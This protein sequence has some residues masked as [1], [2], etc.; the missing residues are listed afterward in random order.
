VCVVDAEEMEYPRS[1]GGGGRQEQQQEAHERAAI[2]KKIELHRKVFPNHAVV[3]WYR[4]VR[5]GGGRGA[6]AGSGDGDG[7][8]DRDDREDDDDDDD[9]P[10]MPTEEDLRVTRTEIGGHY[11]RRPGGGGAGEDA[12][13]GGGGPPLFLLMDASS[14]AANDGKKPASSSSSSSGD[15]EMDEELPLTVYE[16]ISSSSSPSPG[17]GGVAFVNADFELETYEPERIAVERVFR[18][19]P[20]KATS[21]SA[22]GGRGAASTG[23]GGDGAAA[24]AAGG[25]RKAG[26][27]SKKDAEERGR[28]GG[29]G[30]EQQPSAGSSSSSGVGQRFARGPTELDERLESLGSSVR[31]MNLRVSVL[32]EYL[33][34]V[35]GGEEAE[36]DGALLR[37]IDGLVQQLPLVLASLEGGGRGSSSSSSSDNA[38]SPHGRTPLREIEN[39]YDDAMLLAYLAAVAKTARAVHVYSEKFRNACESWKGDPHRRSL[40]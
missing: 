39:E 37:S 16:T 4:V 14:S 8:R 13:A 28:R 11:C 35:E 7:D 40:Y 15:M 6:G 17:G 12:D 20:P 29:E 18:T 2:H 32:C 23:I 1:G 9:A 22:A 36:A 5:G 10:A 33:A 30:R 38:D 27:K 3:G 26:K 21:A 24:A 34:R 31:A 19:R 25:P